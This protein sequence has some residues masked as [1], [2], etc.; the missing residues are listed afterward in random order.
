MANGEHAENNAKLK[1]SRQ[2]GL[3]SVN[4]FEKNTKKKVDH[5]KGQSKNKKNG[6]QKGEVPAPG[7][8]PGPAG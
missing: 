2:A 7:I 8:E 4:R 6:L 1:E 5:K 3:V